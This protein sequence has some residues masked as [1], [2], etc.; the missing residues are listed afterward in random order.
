MTEGLELELGS[1]L[2]GAQITTIEALAKYEPEPELKAKTDLSTLDIA[3]NLVIDDPIRA[4]WEKIDLPDGYTVNEFFAKSLSAASKA[5]DKI[6]A[7]LP[8]KK[9]IQGYPAPVNGAIK[10]D[11]A[12][13]LYFERTA[14]VRSN[15]VVDLE[16]SVSPLG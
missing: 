14:S 7:L 11:G 10:Q 6:N 5:A 2:S 13:T 1:T 12:G 15:I 4:I 9:R 16:L 8:E 3:D